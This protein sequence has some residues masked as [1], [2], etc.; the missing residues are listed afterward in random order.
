MAV[1]LS[2]DPG[3][4]DLPGVWKPAPRAGPV[5]VPPAG[6]GAGLV[7]SQAE[8]LVSQLGASSR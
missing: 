5:P 3:H 8:L 1:L 2:A 4:G 6:P 7:L